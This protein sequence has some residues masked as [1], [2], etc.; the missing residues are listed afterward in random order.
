[1][2]YLYGNHILK[3]HV[4]KMTEDVPEHQGVI[5]FNMNDIP[6]VLKFP[7]SSLLISSRGLQL[8]LKVRLCVSSWI[9]RLLLVFIKLILVNT[10]V[11]KIRLFRFLYKVTISSLFTLL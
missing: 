9:L 6:L 3:A 11:M 7:F 2:S 4:A 8:R 10:C 5:V 1:M